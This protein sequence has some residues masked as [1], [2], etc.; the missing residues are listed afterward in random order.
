MALDL[1]AIRKRLSGLQNQTGKQN[2][3]WKPEPGKQ[4]IRIVPYQFNKDNPFIEL[5]FHYGLNGKT[6]LSPVTH[7]EADPV[8]EFA[9]KLKAT[10]NRD[11]WQMSRKLEPKMRTY[12]PVIVRGQESEGVKLWGFGKTVYQELLSFIA[13]PDYGDITDLNS[14]RDVTVEFMTAAELGKQYPQTTIRIKPNQTPATDN[15]EVAEKIMNGQKDA[16]DIF[17]KVSY[18][19]LKEQ[20]AIWLNPEEGEAETTTETTT[21]APTSTNTKKVDDVNQAFDDLFNS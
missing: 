8:V 13:D 1:D 9:E 21:A 7:G 10:G 20:L 2:N 3:L 12:V 17:K 5:F 4:T 6:F 11:D 18:D 15:K 16:N 14:G 19:E